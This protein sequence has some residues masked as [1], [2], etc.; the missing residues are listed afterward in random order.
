MASHTN[1]SS[2]SQPH[3]FGYTSSLNLFLSPPPSHRK[4][5]CHS[6][7]AL[8][9]CG[10]FPLHLVHCPSLPPC[11]DKTSLLVPYSIPLTSLKY[12][13]KMIFLLMLCWQITSPGFGQLLSLHSLLYVPCLPLPVSC[14]AKAVV[15]LWFFQFCKSVNNSLFHCFFFFLM[16]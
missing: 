3:K 9:L 7:C 14:L 10:L 1:Y 11:M 13:F 6:G 15:I 2:P 8:G 5:G 4:P 16:V 12:H